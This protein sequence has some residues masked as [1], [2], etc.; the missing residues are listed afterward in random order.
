MSLRAALIAVLVLFCP[1]GASAR[2][3]INEFLVNIDVAEDGD[4]MVSETI[5]VTVQGGEIKRG[6]FRD[7]PRFYE[8]DGLRYAYDYDILRVER[9]GKREP[10]ETDREG[11]ALQIRIG[12]PD[13]YLD[14]GEHRYVIEYEVKNQVRYFADYDEIYWNATGNYWSFRIAGARVAVRLPDGAP[15]S[16]TAAYTGGQGESGG[17]YRYTF[18]NGAH[19]FWT[20]RSL[21]RGEGLT[22]AVGFEKGVV[23]PPSPGDLRGE[24]WQRNASGIV[25]GGAVALLSLFY[26]WSFVR[27]GRDPAKGPVFPRYEPPAGLSP[28]GVHHIYHRTLSGHQALIATILNL[29]IKDA[30]KIETQSK[31]KTK[32]TLLSESAENAAPEERNL[33]QGMFKN[34]DSFTP[35]DGTDKIFTSA[36]LSFQAEAAKKFGKPYFRWNAEFLLL[37][38]ILVVVAIIAAAILSID[39]TIWHT[40]GVVLLAVMTAAF[41]YFIPA[42]TPK[43]QATRTEIE[44]FRLYL[45]TAE[46]IYLDAVKVGSGAPPP[47]TVERYERFLPY[48]AALGVEEPWTRHFEKLIP[49]E[50]ADYQPRWVNAHGARYTSLH[51]L[52]QALVAGMASSVA[53]SLP[54]SSSSSGS[55]GGG[56]SGGGGGGG[57]GGG[58]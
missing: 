6:I 31:K 56:F 37:G 48:A 8:R 5:D 20:T 1:L 53:S 26:A 45:K 23:D 9:D 4:I 52:N 11:N 27:V 12:D 36:Y 15:A 51:G 28:A 25:L 58:W 18:E 43:G 7:L 32:L 16:Q 38:I 10:Y 55:G 34:R 3:Q 44:G 33:L 40:A 50:A 47:M 42:P 13:V 30:L 29:G 49:E 57:G 24:W 54:Q 21:L 2:E 39:W 22:V 41:S 19:V 14:Y 35:G 46:K 17:A